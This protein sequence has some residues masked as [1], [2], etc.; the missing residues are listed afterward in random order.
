MCQIE[1]I[2]ARLQDAGDGLNALYGLMDM[3]E[4]MGEKST[5]ISPA[6]LKNVSQ[7]VRSMVEDIH[8]NI[9]YVA[10][11]LLADMKAETTEA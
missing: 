10:S 11:D 3:V 7:L 1:P 8:I 5:P 6:I 2:V 9:E 4:A